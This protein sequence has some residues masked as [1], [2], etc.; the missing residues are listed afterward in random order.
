[1]DDVSQFM[2]DQSAA[3]LGGWGEAA[4]AKYDVAA[5]A[6][7]VRVKIAGGL[8]GGGS[9][10]HAHAPEIVAETTFHIGTEAGFERPAD[11]RDSGVQIGT[12]CLRRAWRRTGQE[13]PRVRCHRLIGGA[14]GFLLGTVAG[15]ADSI[16][17]RRAAA[18][19]GWLRRCLRLRGELT[20]YTD[21]SGTTFR[22]RCR[23]DRRWSSSPFLAH[24]LVIVVPLEILSD[25][26]SLG[27]R[28][29][30]CLVV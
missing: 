27:I 13:W 28:E 20:H 1:L 26:Q 12:A 25:D 11:T 15:R 18:S 19:S 5:D 30:Y 14:V 17:G 8:G 7:G 29:R 22:I 3:F 23:A 4:G 24:V 10:V 2:S 9:A 6:V 21:L 16:A